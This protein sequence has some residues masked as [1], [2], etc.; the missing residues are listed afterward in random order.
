M[1]GMKRTPGRPLLRLGVGSGAAALVW[2]LGLVWAGPA[3][4]GGWA[5]ITLDQVPTDVRAGETYRVGYTAL[6]HG[7][8]PVQS[9]QTAI[10]A[11]SA[12]GQTLSFSGKPQGAPGHYVAEVRLPQPGEWTWQADAGFGPQNLGTLTVLPPGQAPAAP[13]VARPAAGTAAQTA[14]PFGTRLALPLLPLATVC[15][16][17]L[18]LAQLWETVRAAT[19]QRQR[20]AALRECAV[21]SPAAEGVAA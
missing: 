8:T 14:P 13:E 11:R 18:F 17:V 3:L 21:V 10:R 9:A 6:Q 16:G 20:R 4:A 7:I 2:L 1:H 12:D 5:V 19:A 15:A